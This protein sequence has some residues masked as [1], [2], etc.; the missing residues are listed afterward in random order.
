MSLL[1]FDKKE[2]VLEN[3]IKLISFNDIYFDGFTSLK[4]DD[5]TRRVLS[6]IDKAHYNDNTTFIGRTEGLGALNKNLL[7]TGTKTLLNVVSHPDVCFDICECG[8]NVLNLLTSLTTG[9]VYWRTP[10]ISYVGD[11]NCDIV[12]HDVRYTDFYK[13]LDDVG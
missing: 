2:D 3:G 4:D 11:G 10:A 12:F 7:S 9:I 6:E 13:F 1:I 5:F 8:N